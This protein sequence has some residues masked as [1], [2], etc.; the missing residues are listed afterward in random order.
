MVRK[1]LEEPYEDLEYA[2]VQI[3]DSLFALPMKLSDIL[4]EWMKL[5]DR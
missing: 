2:G 1:R 4:A 3:P 5:K